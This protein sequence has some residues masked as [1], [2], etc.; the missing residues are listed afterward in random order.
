VHRSR[1]ISLVW[2]RF[3]KP[4]ENAGG[5]EEDAAN[6]GSVVIGRDELARL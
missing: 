1:H 3:N 5:V 6:E 2:G 4:E